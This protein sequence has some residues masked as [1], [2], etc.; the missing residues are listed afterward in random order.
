[1]QIH[2]TID[3]DT[4]GYKLPSTNICQMITH[5][6]TINVNYFT[7]SGSI[8]KPLRMLQSSRAV[9]WKAG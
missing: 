3:S 6:L 7:H 2:I 1:M 5:D 9:T 8:L 4:Q